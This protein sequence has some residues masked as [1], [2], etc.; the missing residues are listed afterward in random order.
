MVSVNN[1]EQP[2]LQAGE[3]VAVL[4]HHTRN[5]LVT[6]RFPILAW[7]TTSFPTVAPVFAVAPYYQGWR[8]LPERLRLPREFEEPP[9]GSTP[10][11]AGL[12]VQVYRMP[13]WWFAYQGVERV[14]PDGA[15]VFT[16]IE[17]RRRTSHTK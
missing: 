8:W 3:F 4:T 16:F 7:D 12:Y 11:G 2:R 6:A 13:N 15:N 14:G 17:R 1:M 10:G 5:G 9:T